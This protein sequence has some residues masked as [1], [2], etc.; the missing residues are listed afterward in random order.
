MA[1]LGARLR[2]GL[3]APLIAA[4]VGAVF[5]AIMYSGLLA[6]VEWLT[7][8]LR[9][10]IRYLLGQHPPKRDDIIY[11]DIDDK[12]LKRLGNF[13]LPRE[14]YAEALALLG[15]RAQSLAITGAAASGAASSETPAAG[16][17]SAA[18]DGSGVRAVRSAGP[19]LQPA[20]GH[21]GA[22]PT[23]ASAEAPAGAASQGSPDG[24]AGGS[25]PGPSREP[26]GPDAPG[27]AGSD[28]K[29]DGKAGA[30]AS[31]GGE[32]GEIGRGA[33][34]I[35]FDIF[36]TEDS[37]GRITQKDINRALEE[38]SG[39]LRKGG[40]DEAVAR[41]LDGLLSRP[42]REMSRL[43]AL[44]GHTFFPTFLESEIQYLGRS[45]MEREIRRRKPVAEAAAA[46]L[47]EKGN[48]RLAKLWETNRPAAAFELA[49]RL[50][51]KRGMDPRLLDIL[52]RK[53]VEDAIHDR[54][55][56]RVKSILSGPGE[57][58][59]FVTGGS[60]D[61]VKKLLA[62]GLTEDQ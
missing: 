33:A 44:H 3:A 53:M 52:G 47:E 5:V 27:R 1:A 43:A 13:P 31:G 32:R 39:I 49:E 35:G 20:A 12:A 55:V 42:D 19:H 2:K 15:G 40:G 62:A 60:E 22:P 17:D 56:G 34:A 41:V 38:I 9:F 23:D 21:A 10:S 14:Y 46:I 11:L 30:G 57:I 7:Y 45:A 37:V 29:A 4:S 50:K 24:T 61:P 18:K 54:L 36:F 48:E 16:P 58:N 6:R 59:A 51:S 25:A 26:G 8:D 28:G